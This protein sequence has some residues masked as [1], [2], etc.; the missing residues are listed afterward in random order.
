MKIKATAKITF[1][2]FLHSVSV[3]TLVLVLYYLWFVFLDR[4]LIFLYGHL[5]TTPFDDFTTGR[6]WMT[7]LV[8]S[9]MVL[10]GYTLFSLIAKKLSRTYHQPEWKIVWKYSSLTLSLPLFA[11]LSFI[12]KPPMP[13]LLALWILVVLLCGLALALH[14]SGSITKNFRQSMWTFFDGLALIP[15]FFSL[16]TVGV[17]LRKPSLPTI[18][19]F[20]IP[21]FALGISLIWFRIMAFLYRRFKQPFPSVLN[22]FL[23]GLTINFL[24]L[25]LLHYLT[26]RPG[27][28]R[29]ITADSNFFVSNPWLQITSF[30][31]VIGAT[32]MVGQW[33]EKK[34][35]RVDD[36]LPIKKLLLLLTL[37]TLGSFLVDKVVVGK[38]TDVW[39]CKEDKWGQT[40]Q[41]TL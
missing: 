34:K 16:Q 7:G 27:Y 14:V 30:A 39:L 21:L 29:Y 25:P 31:I 12:G 18:L 13:S 2:H 4:R 9:G 6:Y 23:S 3:S 5:H 40:R 15:M 38:E 36:F 8:V 20:I 11:I 1:T 37:L 17:V 10:V 22:I 33:R 41:S 32:L 26:S 24:F 35:R 19:V 28:I